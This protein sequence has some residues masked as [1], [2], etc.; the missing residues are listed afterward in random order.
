V[1]PLTRG[2]LVLV[3][4]YRAGGGAPAAARRPAHD[5]WPR[6]QQVARARRR[7]PR[8]AG[9]ML[10]SGVRRAVPRGVSGQSAAAAGQPRA[11]LVPWV[12][13]GR[14]SSAKK[15]ST[16]WARPFSID[17]LWTEAPGTAPRPRIGFNV[18]SELSTPGARV[19]PIQNSSFSR[20]I[21]LSLSPFLLF[22][23][24]GWHPTVSTR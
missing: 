7:P 5:V 4:C 12:P 3:G 24:L 18:G 17:S 1:E 20:W 8:L 14:H 23:L 21:V 11:L 15:S 6:P 13:P 16:L 10:R 2:Y 22:L 19:L 9:A